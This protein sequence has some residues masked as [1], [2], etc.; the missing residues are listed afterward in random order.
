MYQEHFKL[1]RQPFC[2]HAAA[3][4]LWI[5]DRMTAGNP[6][7]SQEI[8]RGQASL[9]RDIASKTSPPLHDAARLRFGCR[10]G[11]EH[12][13]RDAAPDFKRA[14]QMRRGL[15][16]RARRHRHPNCESRSRVSG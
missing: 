4:A 5:D 8:Q 2:E 9:L 6:K 15:K 14:R 11:T 13:P 1:R 7:G 16:Q 12:P 10:R 3:D